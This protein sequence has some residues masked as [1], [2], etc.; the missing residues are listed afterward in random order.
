MATK[1]CDTLLGAIGISGRTPDVDTAI[2]TAALTAFTGANP[3]AFEAG[4]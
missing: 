1:M 2:D 3:A 4:E